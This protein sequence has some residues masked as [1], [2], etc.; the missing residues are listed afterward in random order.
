LFLGMADRTCWESRLIV[1]SPSLALFLVVNARIWPQWPSPLRNQLVSDPF[2][3]RNGGW[4][5]LGE[6]AQREISIIGT[7]PGLQCQSSATMAFSTQKSIEERPLCFSEWQL[8][9]VGRAGSAGN[10]HHWQGS[11]LA[12]PK[13]FHSGHH[14]SQI[15]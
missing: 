2:D 5:K 15:K 1:K 7:V 13:L 12:M 14:H 9:H 4:G 6:Q 10:L 8:G 3:S 11:S